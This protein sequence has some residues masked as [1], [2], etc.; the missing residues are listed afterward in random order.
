MKQPLS[1]QCIIDCLN[2]NCGIKVAKL[3]LLPL[4]AD[5]NTSVY[6]A[7]A[8]DQSSY[9]IENVFTLDLVI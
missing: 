3:T 6:K 8:H 2:A 7:E 9:F 4:G 1:D 5:L